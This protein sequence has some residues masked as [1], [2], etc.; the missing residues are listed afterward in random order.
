MYKKVK[1]MMAVLA[2]GML[3]TTFT[4]CSKDDEIGNISELIIGKWQLY[5]SSTTLDPCD[6]EGWAEF[7]DDGTC[8]DFDACDGT[9]TSAEYTIDGR[10]ITFVMDMFPDA[11]F[12]YYVV[13]ISDNELVFRVEILGFQVTNK[14]KRITIE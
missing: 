13:S 10:K 12:S 5:Q 11:P 3:V 8:S 7:K 1:L 2:I 9:T 6:F 4:S 14:Y